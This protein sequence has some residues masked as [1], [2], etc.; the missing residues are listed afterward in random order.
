MINK[1]LSITEIAK[2]SG[3][4]IQTLNSF[5]RKAEEKKDERRF[6]KRIQDNSYGGGY[7]YG[8]DKD[9]LSLNLEN[10][11]EKDAELRKKDQEMQSGRGKNTYDPINV[12]WVVG[13]MFLIVF[14]LKWFS[15]DYFSD[16][17][18][19]IGLALFLMML[20]VVNFSVYIVNKLK[21]ITHEILEIKDTLEEIKDFKR[22]ILGAIEELDYSILEEM[23]DSKS[24]I[25][26]AIGGK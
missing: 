26:D 15:P 18:S 5:A 21:K 7:S 24:D 20:F 3:L 13:Q 10:L 22:D 9:F 8:I 17:L 14:A 25:L 4:N 6:I 1:F 23:K 12:Y 16:K 19:R 11:L 2:S